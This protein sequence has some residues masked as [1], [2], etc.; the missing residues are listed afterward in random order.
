MRVYTLEHQ[1][2]ALNPAAGDSLLIIELPSDLVVAIFKVGV[3]NL[4]NDVHEMID[5]GLFRVNNKGSLAGGGSAPTPRLHD[6]GDV[7]SSVVVYEAGNTG[8]ATEPTS[9]FSNP[10][11]QQG[12]SNLSGYEREWPRDVSKCP[13]LSPSQLAGLRLM[14]AV[15]TGFKAQC[16]IEFAEIGG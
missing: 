7:A 9:W 11:D 8:M 1:I 10:Y 4:D 5:V 15:S 14:T 3:Y 12:V 6:G 16:L 2:A 13:I